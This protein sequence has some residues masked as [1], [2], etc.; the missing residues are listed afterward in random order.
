MNVIDCLDLGEIFLM[1]AVFAYGVR[2]MLAAGT[3]PEFGKRAR[4]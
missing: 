3:D 2:W 4:G 1:I